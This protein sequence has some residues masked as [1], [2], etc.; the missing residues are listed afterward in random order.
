MRDRDGA[1]MA[2]DR[3]QKKRRYPRTLTGML[4]DPI[5]MPGSRYP[6][7]CPMERPVG[8]HQVVECLE[9]NRWC[10]A[11]PHSI[12]VRDLEQESSVLR[13]LNQYR[14]GNCFL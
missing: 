6:L 1:S 3:D 9:L 7:L 12:E 14:E 8:C 13:A 11:V 10:A 4:S 5:R 2:A